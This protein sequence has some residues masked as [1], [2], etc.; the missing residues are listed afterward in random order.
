MTRPPGLE[1][2]SLRFA[3]PFFC[4]FRRGSCRTASVSGRL[5]IFNPLLEAATPVGIGFAGFPCPSPRPSPPYIPMASL[6]MA[7]HPAKVAG[8]RFQKNNK[9][10]H[11]L[12]AAK[13]NEPVVRFSAA[14]GAAMCQ[15]L[16]L[17]RAEKSAD[18]LPDFN[19]FALRGGQTDAHADGWG[20][21]RCGRP[22]QEWS[23]QVGVE[24]GFQS[25][26][27]RLIRESLNQ[28]EQT[29]IAHLRRATVGLSELS[30]QH[31]FKRSLWSR[32]WA[33][34]HN[35]H[36]R[37]LDAHLPAFCSETL[38]RGSTDSEAAFC[39]LMTALRARFGSKAP[40]AQALFEAVASWHEQAEHLGPVNSLMSDGHSFFAHCSSKLSFAQLDGAVLF[41]TEPVG[42]APWIA[43]R[44]G[45][46][47]WVEKGRLMAV[48]DRAAGAPPLFDAPETIGEAS[49]AASR[50]L[51]ATRAPLSLDEAPSFEPLAKAA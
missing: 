8:R 32:S 3:L 24:P 19:E 23:V 49:L 48:R 1:P 37:G 22:G 25:P 18:P 15:L 13:T 40:D 31:P 36:L 21:A 28:S 11:C 17:N 2:G 27:A 20:V 16:G 33:F 44:P 26:L 12:H 47:A 45:Q 35:G 5:E 14:K 43:M 41:A 34:A 50:S 4:F 9:S 29:L 42:D 30:N 38:P 51:E 7:G 46:T 10:L 39:W 6:L